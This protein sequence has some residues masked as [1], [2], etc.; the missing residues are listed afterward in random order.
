[1]RKNCFGM[2]EWKALREAASR[3][4]PKHTAAVTWKL[5]NL[6]HVKQEGLSPMPKDRGAEQ[7]DVDGPLECS[8]AQGMVPAETRGSIAARQAAGTLPWSGVNDFAEGQ[9]LHADR[10]ARLQESANFQVAQKSSLVLTTR[11]TRCRRME[12]WRT[13]GTWT[14]VTSCAAQSWCCPFLQDL[15]VANARVGAER[16]PLKTKVIYDLDAAFPEWKIGDFRSLAKTSA[17]TDGSITLGVAVGFRQFIADQPLSKAD[18]TRAMHE[19]VQLCRRQNSHPSRK[20]GSWP[21]QPH[22]AGSRTHNPGG[23]KCCSS[24]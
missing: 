21:Y 22:P 6:S 18:V 3:F 4:L 23:T 14:A 9:R 2:I 15:D 8:L 12:A 5:R 7:G 16:N 13:T 20:F 11:G 1:M 19:R 17:V 24:L 10:S